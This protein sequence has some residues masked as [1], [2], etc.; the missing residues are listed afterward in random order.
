MVQKNTPELWDTLWDPVSK[1]E[2]I[3]NLKK[4]ESSIRWRRIEKEVL[5]KF[6]SFKGL[7]VIELGAGGGTNALLFA[8]RGSEVYV[9]DYS[10]KALKRSQEFFSRH[11]IK[12]NMIMQD[13]LNLDKNLFG[14]FDVSMSFGLAEHFTGKN[15]I[16]IIKSHF[17][18]LNNKGVS[19]IS[20]PNKWNIPY[21]IHKS[22]FEIIGIWRVGEEYPFSRKELKLIS[23]K[24]G[25]NI[26]FIGSSFIS[27]L[28]YINPFQIIRKKQIKKNFE[29]E[30][31][32]PD[33]TEQEKEKKP[34]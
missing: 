27:S 12:S 7:K 8:L 22:I 14:K 3:F 24:L 15:R 31:I 23:L 32:K 34:L 29:M 4:E 18:V 6:G 13:A 17:D 26:N 16:Q 25:K 10:S 2:D 5:K 19:F 20:V 9:L 28:N 11:D 33:V 21:R 30:K 1:E